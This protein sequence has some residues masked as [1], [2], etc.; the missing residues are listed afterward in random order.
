MD[1]GESAGGWEGE[2]V[3]GDRDMCI[4]VDWGVL[5]VGVAFGFPAL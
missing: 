2:V 3:S 4:L 5:G 1:G